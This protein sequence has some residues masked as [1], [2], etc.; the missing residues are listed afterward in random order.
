MDAKRPA[1]NPTQQVLWLRFCGFDPDQ[2][3][4]LVDLKGRCTNDDGVFTQAESKRLAFYRWLH[5]DGGLRE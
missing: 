2:I 4:K 1:I 3:E 5:R